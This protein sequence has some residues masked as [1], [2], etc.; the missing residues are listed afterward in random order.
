VYLDDAPDE[1][2]PE[3]QDQGPSCPL[4]EA[5]DETIEILREQL[6]AEREAHAEA[7]RIIAALT[8]HIPEIEAPR[9]SSARAEERQGVSPWGGPER[10]GERRRGA[11][12]GSPAPV[13]A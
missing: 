8:S 12:E 4:I 9:E 7:R 3:P 1:P 6:R 11:A 5:K 2:G 13:V 10:G